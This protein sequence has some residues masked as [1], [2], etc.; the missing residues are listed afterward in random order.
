[1]AN[2]SSDEDQ[3]RSLSESSSSTSP[4]VIFYT[5][6]LTS[7]ILGSVFLFRK[8]IRPIP[9]SAHLPPSAFRHRR[10]YGLVTS[11]G[12]GD[13]FHFFHTP[14]G[15]LAGWGWLRPLFPVLDL[16][17]SKKSN[18][19]LLNPTRN[20]KTGKRETKWA[21]KKQTLHIRL[22]GI[23]APEAAHF[24]KPAQPYSDESLQW[25]RKFILGR[26]VYIFPLANDQYGRTVSE[27]IV[28]GSKWYNFWRKYNV[29][30]EMLRS[31]WATVYEAKQGVEFNG[32]KV[33]FLALESEAKRKKKGIF[34]QGKKLVTPRQ[35]KN[36]HKGEES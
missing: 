2:T 15:R 4:K 10:L 17:N 1:M 18:Y 21:Q 32:K 8:Y 25:L 36:M 16:P 29:S 3:K 11:V 22:C 12:D 5:T 6:V 30:A 14:G 31:G 24:G 27:V 19:E 33:W 23:D 7:S 9:T 26:M 13:N 28:R 34:I 20:S 35:Y